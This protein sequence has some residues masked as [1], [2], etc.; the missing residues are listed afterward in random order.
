MPSV[1]DIEAAALQP[2]TKRDMLARLLEAKRESDRRN[3]PAK[4][5][6]INKLLQTNPDEFFID[7]EDRGIAGLTHEPLNFKIH[8]PLADIENRAKLRRQLRKE[9]AAQD[10]SQNWNVYDHLEELIDSHG[11]KTLNIKYAAI[12]L[13]F[14]NSFHGNIWYSADSDRVLI[15]GD[16]SPALLPVWQEKFAAFV[17]NIE[18]T[19]YGYPSTFFTEAWVPVIRCK[20]ANAK[21]SPTLK[22]ITDTLALTEGPANQWYGGPRPLSSMLMGGLAGAG[23]GYVGGSL[24]EGLS[25]KF[26]KNK[27]RRMLAILGAGAGAVPG[28]LWALSNTDRFGPKGLISDSDGIVKWNSVKELLPDSTPNEEFY[29][30][31]YDGFGMNALGFNENPIPVDDFGRVLWSYDDPY[32]PFSTRAAASGLVDAASSL[33]GNSSIVMPSDVARMAVG[34][35]SGYMSGTLVGKT[36]GALAGLKPEAQRALQQAGT[37]AGMLNTVMPMAFGGTS[38]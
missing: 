9:A 20:S 13:P 17:N 12:S 25:D 34:M 10:G 4:T 26:E 29:K 28:G 3:Y 15:A 24:I 35:G 23:L 30:A 6:I 7:S 19:E 32:T 36:L 5:A 37:W 16:I 11:D 22:G 18:R 14:R 27:L 2:L 1:L 31:A 38:Y 8:V 21:G 33:R